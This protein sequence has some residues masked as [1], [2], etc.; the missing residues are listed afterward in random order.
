MKNL[1][2]II[3]ANWNDPV[4]S[5]VFAAVI[6]AVCGSVLTALYAIF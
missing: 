2:G 6:L 1:M 3:K 5:K 4:W